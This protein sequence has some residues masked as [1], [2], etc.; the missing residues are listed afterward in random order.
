MHLRRLPA[1]EA[2]VR[3]YVEELWLPYNRDLE[4]VVDAHA[5]ADLEEVDVV[6]EELAFRLD[7]LDEDGYRAWLA[8]D[9]GSDAVPVDLAAGDGD[10]AGF[11]TTE[12]E[13]APSVFDW[14][15]RLVVGDIYVR[16]PHRGTGLA[17]D[18]LARAARR[19]REE[20][21][22]ELRLDVDVDN[23][24]ASAFYDGHGFETHRRQLVAPVD[25]F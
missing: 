21:C 19:A 20:G 10:L 22:A 18:L 6:E 15:D 23:D 12:V 24:R 7:R 17:D 16:E 3:R 2:V 8:V 13:T 5:L 25:E 11:V 14:P 1:D 9:A 4:A